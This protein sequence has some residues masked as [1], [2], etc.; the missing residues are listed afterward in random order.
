MPT[1]WEKMLAGELYDPYGPEL[2]A[3]RRRAR[4]MVYT[5][6]LTRDADKEERLRILGELLGTAGDGVWIEPPFHCDYGSHI[7]LGEKVFFNFGCVLLDCAEIRIGPRTLLAPNVQI[8]TA[9]HPL[10][11]VVRASGLE[12][13][14]PITIG[15]DVWIGGGAILLPGVTVGDR[16][17][18]GAGAVVTKNVPADMIVAGNPA[19]VIGDTRTAS[20]RN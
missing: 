9:T 14:K 15:A 1:E 3:A 13:A 20:A 18:I 4:D 12:S 10:D 19:R 2:S 6:N 7:H 16:A 5:F 17:V 11:P 8:Y